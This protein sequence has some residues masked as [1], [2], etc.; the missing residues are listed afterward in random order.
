M[1]RNIG[2]YL[3]A[4]IVRLP[5]SLNAALLSLNLFPGI[6][7]GKAYRDY[8]DY[9]RQNSEYYDNTKQLIDM[10]NMAIRSVEYYRDRYGNQQINSVEQF[11]HTIEFID[12]DIILTNYNRFMNKFVDLSKYD[13]GTTGGTS[14]KPLTFISPKERYVIELATMHTLWERAGYKFDKRAVIRN[15]RLQDGHAY[16]INPLTREIIFDGFRLTNEYF[17]HVYDTIKRFNIHFVHCYPSTAYEFATYIHQNRLDASIILS[18]L[19]G[20]ENIFD[21]QRELIEG[22]LG[23]RFYNWYGHSEKLVLAGYCAGTN[24]YH[25]EPTYGYFELI[26][27]TGKVIRESGRVGEIVGTSFHNFGMPFIRYKTGDYAEYVGNYCPVCA[28]HLPVIRNIRGRWNGDRIYNSDGTFITTTALNLHND[29]YKII[30]GIQYVQE[31]KGELTVL[32]VKAPGYSS[33]HEA[34][35]YSHFQT[36]LHPDAIVKIQYVDKLLRKSN[37]KFVHIISTVDKDLN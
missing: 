26:D 6:I 28:R 18:F 37:G 12:K 29:L 30:N 34:A 24:N 2:N 32:I 36:K 5:N 31:K 9:L 21:Y 17:A 25:V 8:K 10:L 14:G 13:F 1:R 15:H 3:N 23:I 11:E 7:F 27:E 20:S 33:H 35:L 22:R 4:N 16:K 19:S